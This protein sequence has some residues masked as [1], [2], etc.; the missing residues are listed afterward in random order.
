MSIVLE[1]LGNTS[2]DVLCIQETKVQDPDFP[3]APIEDAGYN[4]V[5]KGQKSYNGVAI[6]SRVAPTAVRMGFD[7]DDVQEGPRLIAATI[8]GVD[9]INTYVPQ[10]Q[11]PDSD[12][13]AYKLDWLARLHDYFAC[14]YTTENRLVWVGDFNVAPEPTDVYDSEKLAG[15]VGYHPKEHEALANIK[16]WGFVDVYRKHHPDEKVFTFWDYRIRNAV[17]NGLG[18]RIDHVWATRPMADSSKNAW[19]DMAP[20]LM[21]KPSD[22]TFIVAEFDI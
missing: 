6:L 2:P 7:G 8:E 20:R 16:S 12:K 4:C 15:S 1:W 11:A 21:P 19:I 17:K 3:L 9:V 18:W 22:H 10:G 13:F 14:Y 5:F